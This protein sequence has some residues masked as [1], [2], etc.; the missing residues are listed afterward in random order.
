MKIETKQTT[1]GWIFKTENERRTL[2]KKK[3]TPPTASFSVF[4]KMQQDATSLRQKLISVKKECP[5]NRKEL[6]EIQNVVAEGYESLKN[7][8]NGSPETQGKKSELEIRE[9]KMTVR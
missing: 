9:K 2:K 1:K 7:K 8:I 6:L 3:K 4:R 5:R